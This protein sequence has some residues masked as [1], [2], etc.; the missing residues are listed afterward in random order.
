MFILDLKCGRI[1]AQAQREDM[2]QRMQ[3]SIFH[4]SRIVYVVFNIEQRKTMENMSGKD[5]V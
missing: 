5:S 1:P 4:S 2:D 3:F